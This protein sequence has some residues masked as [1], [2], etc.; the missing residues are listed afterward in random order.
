MEA[1]AGPRAQRRRYRDRGGDRVAGIRVGEHAAVAELLDQAAGLAE[2]LLDG[3]AEPADG[4]DR[5]GVA[6]AVRVRGEMA[7]IDEEQRNFNGARQQP[8]GLGLDLPHRRLGDL[9]LELSP[10]DANEERIGERQQRPE[11]P[12][13]GR[14]AGH[15]GRGDAFE[16]RLDPGA[17]QVQLGLGD[18]P[19]RLAIDAS[20]LR[21][22]VLGPDGPEPPQRAID[23]GL[24]R[25]EIGLSGGGSQQAEGAQAGLDLDD[26]QASVRLDFSGA[27]G[28]P[29]PL[30][31]KGPLEDRLADGIVRAASR[32]CSA[33]TPTRSSPATSARSSGPRASSLP[34]AWAAASGAEA[35]SATAMHLGAKRR[36]RVQ[37]ARA[38]H[39]R[40]LPGSSAAKRRRS[41]S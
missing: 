33:V 29:L 40:S 12:L 30:G 24:L 36:V 6:L 21:A 7:Q 34:R 9:V 17:K 37:L 5:Y 32:I 11:D 25:R 2:V 22:H 10:V 26:G 27:H 19:Q 28:P 14:Q 35:R 38:E 8:L 23:P 3:R 4:L 18:A 15:G 41:G 20:D 13:D 1:R 16:Q 39:R 31:V